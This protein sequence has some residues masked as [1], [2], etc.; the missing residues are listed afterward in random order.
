M[1][2]PFEKIYA[3]TIEKLESELPDHL[4]YH[5]LD[6]IL[7][8][9]KR[10]EY[11]A[12]KEGID[13]YNTFLIK[14]AALYHDMGFIISPENH[15][16]TS[17]ELARNELPEYNLSKEDIE[18]ICGMIMATK[19]PQ[20]PQNDLE[21]VLADADLEYLST[22]NFFPV[23]EKLFYELKH[24]NNDLNREKWNQIQIK[25]ISNHSY[26]TNYCKH[27]KEFRKKRNLNQLI[28][29]A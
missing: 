20:N 23:S 25:F 3:N 10:A 8:V 19:I 7:Y 17:C 1:E 2:E 14:V 16:E 22:K 13:K 15:E 5:S 24:F 28:K 29:S 9:L 11:I 27:Y 12:N 18:K 6:H 21:K 26:H 4:T